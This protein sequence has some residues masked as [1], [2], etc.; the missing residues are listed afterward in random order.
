MY[1]PPTPERLVRWNNVP[2]PERRAP[3][4]LKRRKQTMPRRRGPD[5]HWVLDEIYE[6]STGKPIFFYKWWEPVSFGDGYWGWCL[7][8]DDEVDVI[9]DYPHADDW[10]WYDN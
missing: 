7:E 6:T 10:H 8:L 5:G 1:S 4:R 9:G 2:E 3:P